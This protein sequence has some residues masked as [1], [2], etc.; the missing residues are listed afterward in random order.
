M[1]YS[2]DFKLRELPQET[3]NFVMDALTKFVS[4]MLWK[5]VYPYEYMD[6]CKKFKINFYKS[7]EYHRRWRQAYSESLILTTRATKTEN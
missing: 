1:I 5:G 3:T 6:D 7:G 2:K 4:L